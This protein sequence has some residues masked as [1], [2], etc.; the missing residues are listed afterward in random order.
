M[1]NIISIFLLVLISYQMKAQAALDTS[2][3]AEL[4]YLKEVAEFEKSI[5]YKTGKVSL[6][7]RVELNLPKGYKF[8]PKEEAEKILFDH[9]GNPQQDGIEGMLALDSFKFYSSDG[10]AFVITEDKDGYVKDEDANDINYDDLLK[11]LQDGEKASNEERKKEGYSTA[12]TVGW[13]SKPFYD[14]AN[15]ILHWAK[16]IAFEG[17]E[18]NTLNYDVRILGRN[19]L[20]SM[21]AVGTMDNLAEVKSH[22][23]QI[24]K[25]AT[26]KDGHKYSDFDSKTDNVAAYTVGGL[27]A[28]KLLAKAGIFALLL[29][30]IKLLLIGAVALFSLF[31]NKIAGLFGSKPKEEEMEIVTESNDASIPSNSENTFTTSTTSPINEVS[32]TVTSSETVAQVEDQKETIEHTIKD[33]TS[34]GE[35]DNNII[36]ETGSKDEGK[37]PQI[38]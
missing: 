12:S 13:A 38:S 32:D 36:E 9:W 20:L 37:D 2:L 21:N 15:K 1:K 34:D 17:S 27:V 14:N 31:K 23:P 29:K 24:I 19:G 6:S 25:M 10:W 28:G 3:Q 4:E 7:E 26:F 18:K 30:N 22:I 33:I 16:E 35:V 5:P 8:I 11:E